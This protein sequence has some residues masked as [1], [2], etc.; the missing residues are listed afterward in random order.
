[1]KKLQGKT[2]L[3]TGS[4]RGVGKIVAEA[5]AKEGCRVFV[6]GRTLKACESTLALLS[7]AGVEGKA[8]AA[9]L[10]VPA[11][12]DRL[13]AEVTAAG[14]VDILYNNAA[15]QCSYNMT[16]S[17]QD[18]A[19]WAKVFQT[20]VFAPIRLTSLLVDDIKKRGWGRIINVT[21]GI[22]KAWMQAA[23][24]SSKWAL[25]KWTDDLGAYVAGSGTVVSRI[26]PGWLRTDLGGPNA[27]NAP[28][29]VLPGAMVPV[30]L[31]SD[32]PQAQFF[33]AQ[34]LRDVKL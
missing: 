34:D 19:D 13:A 7:A 10:N 32:A 12:V 16:I 5:L 14:G 30:L 1:M 33:R 21:S 18:M 2:A 25:D 22:D 29:T 17:K 23:Y 11:D 4:S 31:A 9:D 26:D 3:V 27:D 24:G 6:H 8:F 20:N 28:E 15:I